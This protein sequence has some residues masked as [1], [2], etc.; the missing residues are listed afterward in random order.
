MTQLDMS[1]SVGLPL[2]KR[3]KQA[4]TAMVSSLAAQEYEAIVPKPE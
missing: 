4:A 2:P 1:V 3:H